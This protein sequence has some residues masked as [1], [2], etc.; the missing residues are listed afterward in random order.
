MHVLRTQRQVL[1]AL[2]FDTPVM[3]RRH[4]MLC[5]S[6]S[7]ASYNLSIPYSTMVLELGREVCDI[8]V[9]CLAEQSIDT[10][11]LQSNQLGASLLA[12]THCTTKLLW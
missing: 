2:E 8:Y 3:S 11:F 5:P 4:Y 1:G 7:S 9:Q 6:L 12:T 10:Y